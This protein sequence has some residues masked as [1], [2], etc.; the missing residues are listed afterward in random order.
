MTS[1]R[2]NK[3][4]T[5]RLINEMAD[6]IEEHGDNCTEATMLCQY[7]QNEVATCFPSARNEVRRRQL[8]R[9]T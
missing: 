8:Q 6:Y 2:I 9:A 1:H 7:S 3:D 5:N 4:G